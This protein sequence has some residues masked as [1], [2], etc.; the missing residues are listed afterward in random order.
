[1]SIFQSIVN[2]KI[3]TITTEELLKY[4]KQFGVAISVNE[5]KQISS[6]LRGRQVDIF[7]KSER[8]KLLKEIERLTSPATAKAVSQLVT[9]FTK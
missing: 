5:A 1:M 6:Y 4:A 9:Q 7:N 8:A 3:N 2:Q